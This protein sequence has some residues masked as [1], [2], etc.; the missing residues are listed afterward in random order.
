MVIR[1][2]LLSLCLWPQMIYA[3]VNRKLVIERKISQL[4]SF[5]TQKLGRDQRAINLWV[6]NKKG[7]MPRVNN[8]LLKSYYFLGILHAQLYTK[9]SSG[10][11]NRED[12]TNFRKARFYLKAIEPYEYNIDKVEDRL[13][14][15]ES[16]RIERMKAITNSYWRLMVQYISYQEL[17]LLKDAGGEENIT[18]PQ[19]GLCFGGQFAYGNTE[20]EWA[21]DACAYASS[22][23]VGAKNPA[24][25]F[26]QDVSSKGLYVKPTYWKL[27]A[28]GEA[29]IGLGV[30][31]LL[32][33]VDYTEPAGV[34]VESRRVI[35][36]GF[37]VDGRWR[38]TPTMNLTTTAAMVDGS[39]LW[40]IGLIYQL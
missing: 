31:V 23:N 8:R 25:Y 37:S 14:K 20:Y 2:L 32:R 17:A 39:M 11:E 9:Y 36:F 40:S 24:R 5:T 6:K 7:K 34:T 22:G 28:E 12:L 13:S 38:M 18:S 30:P 26:Q 4:E 19:R 29:G 16:V 3:Q 27:L 33:T 21:L 15:M 1:I 35:P 10:E